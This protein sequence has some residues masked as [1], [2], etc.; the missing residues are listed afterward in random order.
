MSY[1]EYAS[2]GIVGQTTSVLVSAPLD[3][4]T[5]KY[6]FSQAPL[7]FNLSNWMVDGSLYLID[8]ISMQ[9]SIPSEKLVTICSTLPSLNIV[10]GRDLMPVIRGNLPLFTGGEFSPLQ[11][12][13][14]AQQGDDLAIVASGLLDTSP[15]LAGVSE[16]KCC[17]S[18]RVYEITDRSTQ[19][20]LRFGYG[21]VWGESL[22]S[23]RDGDDVEEGNTVKLVS[24]GRER[25]TFDRGAY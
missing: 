8:G 17:V 3:G 23:L 4:I 20:L 6:R 12:L 9:W 14:T 5:M 19:D 11:T 7:A 1:L 21:R 22:R 2:S 18:L 25:F 13:F 24:T 10:R 16:V 15:D